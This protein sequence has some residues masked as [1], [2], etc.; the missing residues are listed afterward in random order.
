MRTCTASICIKRQF[1]SDDH[2]QQILKG[3]GFGVKS[4]RTAEMSLYAGKLVCA[5]Q[6]TSVVM[7]EAELEISALSSQSLQ[8]FLLIGFLFMPMGRE[9]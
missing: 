8:A 1:A 9:D 6:A 7:F 3:M 2:E 4:M 5:A